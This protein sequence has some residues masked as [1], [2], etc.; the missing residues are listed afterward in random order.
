[1]NQPIMFLDP[2]NKVKLVPAPFYYF[3]ELLREK[4]KF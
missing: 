3:L 1:M 2:D 4:N